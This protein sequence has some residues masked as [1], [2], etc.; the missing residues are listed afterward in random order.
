M[1]T[2]ELKNILNNHLAELEK[3]KQHFTFIGDVAEV[4][5]IEVVIEET[6]Q[7]IKKIDSV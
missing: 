3:Q 5:K 4:L 7:T 2:Q 1:D 6:K